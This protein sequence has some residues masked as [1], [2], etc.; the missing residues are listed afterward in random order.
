M[1]ALQGNWIDRLV[2]SFNPRAG[3]KRMKAR[4]IAHEVKGYYEGASKR[5]RGVNWRRS[6]SDAS[7]AVRGQL[8]DLRAISRDLDRNNPYASRGADAVVNN[9]IGTGILPQAKDTVRER[10][11]IAH[12]DSTECDADGK[13]D[14]YGL[15]RLAMRTVVVSGEVIIRRRWRK[16]SDGLSVPFQMQVL[17]PDYLDHQKEGVTSAGNVIVQGV[18]F[19]QLGRIRGYWLFNQHPGSMTAFQ[20]KRFQSKFVPAKDVIHMFRSDRPGQVRGV[21]WLA[22]VMVRLQDFSDYEHA[23]LVRQKIA[24]CFAAFTR[25]MDDIEDVDADPN[26]D[27]GEFLD[28]FTPGMIEHLGPGKDITF[29]NPPQ[30][31]DYEPYTRVSLRA[32]AS[33]LGVTYEAITGDL[34]KT[35]FSSGRMGWLEM[36]RSIDVNRSGM[37]IPQF[38]RG[39]ERW[40]EEAIQIGLGRAASSK[41]WTWT[42]PRREMIDP[43]REIPA[44]IKEVRAGLRSRSD[45][46]RRSGFDPVEVYDELQQDNQMADERDLVLDSD[47]RRVT[48]SGGSQSA[49]PDAPQNTKEEDNAQ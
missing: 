14:L 31:N 42:A 6:V 16:A 20:L 48:L 18:E 23:Q 37:F 24:A 46:I 26:A 21:P 30:T 2:F 3:L 13:H 25:D 32:V 43:T 7:G 15:Q 12:A 36:S 39:Y 11:L 4:A 40:F 19:D 10:L 27:E 9:T 28:E 47:P 44:V 17:E 35:N 41:K 33:T 5:R 38:C 49:M 1:T 8:S 45:A 29:A 22:P 34:T